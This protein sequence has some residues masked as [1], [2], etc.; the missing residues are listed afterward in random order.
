MAVLGF[1]F[2][3]FGMIL[4][5][6]RVHADAIRFG[7]IREKGI[8]QTNFAKRFKQ[9]KQ[10]MQQQ[11]QQQQQQKGNNKS[12]NADLVEYLDYEPE[13]VSPNRVVWRIWKR[14]KEETTFP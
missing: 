14:R 4:A 6:Q 11:Q 3:R 5:L 2:S 7:E 13:L 10:Q 12:K 8:D 9:Q 1:L